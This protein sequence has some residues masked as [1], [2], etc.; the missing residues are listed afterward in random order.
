MPNDLIQTGITYEGGCRRNRHD[1]Q[2][3]KSIASED[4]FVC[5]GESA[6]ETRQ[7]EQDRWRF[8]WKS[9]HVDECGDYDMRDLAHT[10][11]VMGAALAVAVE[12]DTSKDQSE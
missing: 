7:F 5:C 10:I 1:C 12:H 11:S 4:S 9:Q 2:S 6:P 8:C 3:V